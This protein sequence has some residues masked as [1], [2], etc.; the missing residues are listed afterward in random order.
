MT[1][2]KCEGSTSDLLL[3]L[4]GSLMEEE[5]WTAF[6]DSF[7]DY[8]DARYATLILT[9]PHA[10]QPGII[11]TPGTNSG[12]RAAATSFF[13]LDP[14]TGLPEG[15]VLSMQ[16]YVGEQALLNSPFYKLYLEP[17]RAIHVMGVDLRAGSGF[18][19]RLRFTR[20][21][22]D[23]P[24][25]VEDCARCQRL[26][27]HLR[28]ALM[29]FDELE[30]SRSEFAVY[31]GAIEQFSVGAII[32]DHDNN[33]LRYNA[34]ARSLFAQNDGLALGGR[35]IRLGTPSQDHDLRQHLKAVRRGVASGGPAAPLIMRL[36]RPSGKRDLVMVIKA[37]RTPAYMQT[38]AAPAL[39]LFISDPERPT[40]VESD[41]LQEMF[42]LTPMEARISAALANGVAPPDV[43][44]ELS[45]APNTVRSHL[46]SV[47][48][49]L[50]VQRQSQLVH[51]IRTS[52]PELT[53]NR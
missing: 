27:P 22:G 5:P 50:G 14:F 30:T 6:L 44:A 25:G 18:E 40:S 7:R 31:S 51:L 43:A 12:D 11:I 46:R 19:A 16:D 13:S 3:R 41:A 47:F 2:A 10:K 21:L 34:V 24:F 52:L 29:L 37:I 4:Y 17:R 8:L 45:I 39:S 26:V 9:P 36:S 42:G 20:Q 53:T 38:G 28:Q 35:R 1:L 33:V 15:E 49:K 48:A 32:L 23:E